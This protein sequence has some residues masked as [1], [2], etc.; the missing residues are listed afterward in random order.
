VTKEKLLMPHRIRRPG[1]AGFLILAVV[2]VAVAGCGGSSKATTNAASTTTTPGGPGGARFAALRTCLAKNGITLPQRTPGQRRPPGAGGAGAGGFFGGGAGGAGAAGG[3]G[4]RLP[5]GVTLAQYQAAVAKCGGTGF[6]ARRTL[7]PAQKAAE[8][9]ALVKFVACM[10]TNGIALPAPNT[11]GTGP[12]F[13]TSKVNTKSA[14]FTAAYTKCAPL[15]PARFG[16]GRGGPPP[17][18]GT[19]T[20]ATT[21]S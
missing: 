8:Q 14:A 17:A 15:L 19:S 5:A 11:T 4:P 7:T 21:T 6:G 2:S 10:H 1:V 13:N 20:T 12:V 16:R 9:A 18:G 3:A